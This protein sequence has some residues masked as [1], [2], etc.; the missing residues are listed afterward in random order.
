MKKSLFALAVVAA[1]LASCVKSEVVEMADSRAIGFEPFVGKHTRAVVINGRSDLTNFYVIGKMKDNTSN[2]FSNVFTFQKVYWSA[3]AS[4]QDGHYEYNNGQ[5]TMWETNKKYY[6]A[7]VSNGNQELTGSSNSGNDINVTYS[8][9][10]SENKITISDYTVNDKDLIVDIADPIESG[11]DM[12]GKETVTFDFRHLL[13]RVRFVINNGDNANSSSILAIENLNFTGVKTG[14]CVYAWTNENT[15]TLDWTLGQTG[16]YQY[17][18]ETVTPSEGTYTIIPS[19]NKSFGNFVI[20]QSNEDVEVSFSLVTYNVA[21]TG[22]EKTYT[23]T[24]RTTHTFEL[25]YD[26]YPDDPDKDDYTW[27]AGKVY[28]YTVTVGGTINY[29]RFD[30]NVA[31][32]NFDLDG[33]GTAN[34]A[35]DIPLQ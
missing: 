2:A 35:D 24:H 14:S 18:A 17:T 30:A 7:A 3:G 8:V 25:T 13:T 10:D 22:N 27:Q 9:S 4:A 33:N 31:A 32:W 21:G 1:T 34:T 20:P 11:T 12:T 19:S 23:E 26:N 28:Q 6:F 29:I 16:K 5:S 15:H